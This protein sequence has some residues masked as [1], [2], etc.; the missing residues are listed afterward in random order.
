MK[1][2]IT[3]VE[4]KGFAFCR[5]SVMIIIWLAFIF[6]IRWLVVLSFFILLFSAIFTVKYA[7]LIVLWRYSLGLIFKSKKEILDIKAMRFA[8]S[9][10]TLLSGVCI[11]LLYSGFERIGWAITGIFAVIKTISALGFCP[12]SKLYTCMSEGSCCAFS[13]K[14][15]RQ[16][17]EK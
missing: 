10:G 6:K 11:V 4:S 3:S 5:Y 16:E 14:I 13:R 8:H 17:K 15:K 7:P 9:L 2:E 1:Q 12:A